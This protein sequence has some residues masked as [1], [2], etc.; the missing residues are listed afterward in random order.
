MPT[1][2]E[3]VEAL[4]NLS[5][6]QIIALTKELEQKWGVKAE[7]QAVNPSGGFC[8]GCKQMIY[9]PHACP[10]NN[11][12]QAEFNVVLASVP[13]DKKMSV[14]KVVREVLGLGLKESKDLVEAAP[15]TIKESVSKEEATDLQTK[16]TA[17]GAVIEVK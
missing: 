12:A 2:E 5:V 13:A 17:A 8:D 11:D 15:K 6:M 3:V 14:I 16:L 4:G 1:K 10:G 9:G 7:P